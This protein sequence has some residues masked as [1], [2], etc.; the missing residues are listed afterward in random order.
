AVI[1]LRSAEEAPICIF[2]KCGE[3]LQQLIDALKG[4]PQLGVIPIVALTPYPSEQLYR[5]A[6]R[7]GADDCITEGVG[8]GIFRRVAN[9]ASGSAPRLTGPIGRVLVAVAEEQARRTLGR[10]LLSAGYEVEFAAGEDELREKARGSAPTLVV[11][12]ASFPSI[13]AAG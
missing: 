10:R 8:G 6:P 4:S 2:V 9:V 5:V 12:S 7:P 3:P 13:G 1:E 11:A